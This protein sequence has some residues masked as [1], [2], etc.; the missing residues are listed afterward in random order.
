M[1]LKN[2]FITITML[3][4]MHINQKNKNYEI[5]KLDINRIYRYLDKYTKE[6]AGEEEE[7]GEKSDLE[8]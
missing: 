2:I 6:N 8:D 4:N 1:H 3:K 7:E 5:N